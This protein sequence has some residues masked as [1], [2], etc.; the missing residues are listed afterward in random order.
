MIRSAMIFSKALPIA[1]KRQIGL[2]FGSLDSVASVFVA[3][4]DLGA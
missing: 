4:G 3:L 1:S 2:T